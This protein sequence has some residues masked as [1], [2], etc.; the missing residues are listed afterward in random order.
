M[1]EKIDTIQDNLD[2]IQE[3]RQYILELEEL[4]HDIPDVIEA[5][6]EANANTHI[7]ICAY[8]AAI[9]A[10]KHAIDNAL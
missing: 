2:L 3:Q 9:N 5:S 10:V 8:N 7:E 1:H 4:I 6:M